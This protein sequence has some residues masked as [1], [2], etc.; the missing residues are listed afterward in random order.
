MKALNKTQINAIVDR[1]G[2]HAEQEWN[3][4]LEKRMEV[5]NGRQKATNLAAEAEFMRRMKKAGF[6]DEQGKA[7]LDSVN[8]TYKYRH[9][10]NAMRQ[11]LNIVDHFKTT[12]DNVVKAGKFQ[13]YDGK[14]RS[15]SS[16]INHPVAKMLDDLEFRLTMADSQMHQSVMESFNT[17]LKSLLK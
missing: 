17:E 8:Q 1:L 10:N 15:M 7:I 3:A 5:L 12:K 4:V 9:T 6:T 14:Y 11:V 2:R 13:Y 16:Y